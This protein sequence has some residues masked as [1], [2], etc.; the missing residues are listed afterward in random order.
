MQDR[1][2]TQSRRWLV[3]CGLIG[4]QLLMMYA[5]FVGGRLIAGQNQR[6]PGGPGEPG[7]LPSQL[8]KDPMAGSGTVQKITGNIITLS[9]GGGGGPPG[10]GGPG[11]GPGGAGGSSSSNQTE[12]VVAADTKYLKSTSS[13]M[14][15]APGGNSGQNQMQVQD[16][17]LGDIKV[18]NSVMVWGTKSG[19]KITAEVVF[20]QSQGMGP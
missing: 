16:A 7:Q 2:K 8:P 17:V 6:N 15:G 12:V 9:G 4:L 3:V 18:G 13:G 20:L 5:A 19:T 1:T 10:G 14:G 11:G